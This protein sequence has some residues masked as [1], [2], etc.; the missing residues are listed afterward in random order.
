MHTFGGILSVTKN[1]VKVTKIVICWVCKALSW[2]VIRDL[3][4]EKMAK[5]KTVQQ[6]EQEAKRVEAEIKLLKLKKEKEKLSG[7]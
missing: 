1:I 6:L 7:R 3:E 4:V 2:V 5:K